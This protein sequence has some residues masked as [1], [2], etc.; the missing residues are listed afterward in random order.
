MNPE[1]L[2]RLA[3]EIQAATRR[4]AEVSACRE[5]VAGEVHTLEDRLRQRLNH[6]AVERVAWLE[7]AREISALNQEL[8]ARQ[9][10]L[11]ELVLQVQ[12]AQIQLERLH[13]EAGT[14]LW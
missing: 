2:S 12:G 11:N 8:R 6:P 3:P 1:S 7:L 13:R 14:P 4:L 9:R 5:A 10:R